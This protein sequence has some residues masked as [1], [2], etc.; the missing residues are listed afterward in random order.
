[1]KNE[2]KLNDVKGLKV[3][4]KKSTPNASGELRLCFIDKQIHIIL[5]FLYE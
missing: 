3:R 2:E 1:M 5:R 4:Y